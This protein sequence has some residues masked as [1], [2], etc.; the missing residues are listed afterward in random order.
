MF[1]PAVFFQRAVTQEGVF[2][3]LKGLRHD[4]PRLYGDIAHPC[5][6]AVVPEIPSSVRVM[7]MVISLHLFPRFKINP[8]DL[9]PRQL[10]IG[11]CH[12]L[13]VFPCILFQSPLLFHLHI[14]EHESGLFVLLP[15]EQ[16]AFLCTHPCCTPLRDKYAC[17]SARRAD[18]V[19]VFHR[20]CSQPLVHAFIGLSL[21]P[22]GI[23][24]SS[25]FRTCH[26]CPRSVFPVKDRM[27]AAEDS[28]VSILQ[29]LPFRQH[30]CI[31]Y[32]LFQRCRPP[33]PPPSVPCIAFFR[34]DPVLPV[35]HAVPPCPCITFCFLSVFQ[36]SPQPFF[37][38]C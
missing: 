17:I 14:P 38:R 22:S 27:P 1:F 3:L 25:A 33:L 34:S 36:K 16:T 12:F 7:F 26:R 4:F 11:P 21:F 30:P 2:Y 18:A 8:C 15:E 10:L 29:Y 6:V 5:Q 23:R 31:F 13:S 35:L 37:I 9:Q 24:H 32:P 28:L 19:M 20:L